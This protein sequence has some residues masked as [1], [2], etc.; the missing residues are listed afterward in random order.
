VRHPAM[1]R[2]LDNA[3]NAANRINENYARE[4]MEL[5]TLGVDGGYSQRDV[6]EMARVLTGHGVSLRP[7]DEPPPKLRPEWAQQYVRRGLYEFN[8]QRHDWQPKELLGRPLQGQGM[9]E[10][11]E[12]LDRLARAPATA[13]FVTRK[14]AAYLVG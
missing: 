11:D 14:M 5:H 2:Y 6:Q 8:P 3:Q 13:R 4:L 7:L 1:L 12:A 9:A 10:L